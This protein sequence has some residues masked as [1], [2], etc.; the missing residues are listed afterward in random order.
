MNFLNQI[1][2]L[3]TKRLSPQEYQEHRFNIKQDAQLELIIEFGGEE[4]AGTWIDAYSQQF[5]ELLSRADL[6]LIS[7]LDDKETRKDALELIRTK[8]YPEHYATNIH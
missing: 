1:E 3:V 7:R 5:E 4:K 2:N 6:D 8:L